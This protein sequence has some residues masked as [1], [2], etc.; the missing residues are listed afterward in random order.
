MKFKIG[1]LVRIHTDTCLDN[2]HIFL[3]LVVECRHKRSL[4][5]ILPTNS[6]FTNLPYWIEGGKLSHM[7]L[8]L[9]T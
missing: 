3:A 8:P 1:D 6:P 9:P 7:T 2:L 4:Y 5:K